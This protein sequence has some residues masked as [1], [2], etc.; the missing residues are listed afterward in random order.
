MNGTSNGI[1]DS[2]RAELLR[3]RK[4]PAVWIVVGAWLALSLMFGYLFD[5]LAYRTGDSGFSNEGESRTQLLAGLLPASVPDVMVQGLPM[6]GGALVMVL[7]ALASG[8]GFGWGTWKT[9]Y[10]QGRP[11]TSVTLGSLIAVS[12]FVVL[13]MTLSTALCLGCSSLIASTVGRSL[14]MPG[15]GE[16]AAS[17]GGGLLVLEMWALLGF[18][19]GVLAKG[20]A[21]A[22]GLGL[23]WSLVVENLLRGVGG[24]LS[25][26]DAITHVLPGTAGGSLV[27]A[28]IGEAGGAPGVLLSISGGR[29]LVTVVAYVVLLAGLTLVVVRRRDVA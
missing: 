9:V 24:L 1:V 2:T 13:V 19:V 27:G 15:V 26:V 11:R 20:P 5:Y 21:L 17:F 7:G 10:T 25:V 23:V 3:L 4:W 12:A 8:N 28:L 14:T 22:V 18:A 29:A 6:F 16:L